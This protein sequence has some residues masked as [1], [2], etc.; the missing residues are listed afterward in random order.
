[1]A[2]RSDLHLYTAAT[3][4]GWKPL[5]MLEELGVDYEMT[6]IEFSKRELAMYPYARSYPWARV[7]IDG[8]RHLQAWF[9]RL[10]AR[11]AVHRAVRM[12]RPFLEAFGVGDI[13][14]ETAANAARFQADVRPAGA[15]D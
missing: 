14:G 10:E 8:L 5:I 6:H 1:M 11:P 9:E 4:N 15:G 13:E 2:D 12:P 3:M 7:S